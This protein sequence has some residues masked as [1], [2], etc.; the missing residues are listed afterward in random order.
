MFKGYAQ[1]SQ[2][3]N[4]CFWKNKGCFGG[5]RESTG[6]GEVYSSSTGFN[7]EELTQPGLLPGGLFSR[8]TASLAFWIHLMLSV[9]FELRDARMRGMEGPHTTLFL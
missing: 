3:H 4:V 9:V 8:M 2:R 1:P 7:K 5:M 6:L